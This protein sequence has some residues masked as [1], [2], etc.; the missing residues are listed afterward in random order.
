LRL[1]FG[2]AQPNAVATVIDAGK[3]PVTLDQLLAGLDSLT[4]ALT[5]GPVNEGAWSRIKRELSGLFVIRHATAPSPAPQMLLGHARI[6][7]VA[8][9]IEEAVAEL[10]RLPGAAGASD[11]FTAA[12]RYDTAHRALDVL[13]SS[14]VLDNPP[15]R[16]GNK[17][18]QQPEPS[19]TATTAVA[20]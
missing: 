9:R 16:D 20:G 6:L 18:A 12:R 4:P 10:R 2:N 15:V 7:L 1:R 13:E 3:A 8:G 14:A 19:A 5:E 11:W 17:V